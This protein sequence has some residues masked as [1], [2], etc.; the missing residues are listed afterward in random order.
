MKHSEVKMTQQQSVIIAGS[1]GLIGSLLVDVALQHPQ[2]ARVISLSRH[3]IKQKNN[4]LIQIIDPDLQIA[5]RFL[6]P[7]KPS[8]GFITLGSTKKKAGSKV[9]LKVV[10]V[11]LV[12]NVAKA[13]KEAG[14]KTL[15]IV[16]CIGA[17][18]NALSHYLK[19]K[20]EMEALI[21]KIGFERIVFMQPGPLVGQ[22][23]EQRSDE[24]LLQGLM[25]LFNP[26]MKGRLLNY[27]PIEADIVAKSMLHLAF[28]S[29]PK[30]GIQRHTSQAM[31]ALQSSY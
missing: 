3:I 28:K 27:K 4:R 5:A 2:I 11:T 14:V 29:E 30:K 6:P 1:T 24:R 20:G 9:A 8:I 25:K 26:V 18:I 12:V 13:M 10:D 19:C 17:S 7:E 23:E 22:R 16:S 31:F 21:E 15:C